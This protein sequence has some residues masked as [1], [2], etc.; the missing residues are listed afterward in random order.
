MNVER[1]GELP[2]HTH[3]NDVAV[4]NARQVLGK[5]G[6]VVMA[7]QKRLRGNVV[8]ELVVGLCRDLLGL[9]G[10]KLLG[11]GLLGGRLLS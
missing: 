8:V 7:H 6:A 5:G 3:A 11:G 9:L 1:V 4:L 2:I 10:N